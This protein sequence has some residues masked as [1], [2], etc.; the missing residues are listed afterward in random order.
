MEESAPCASSEESMEVEATGHDGKTLDVPGESPKSE[1][2][3]SDLLSEERTSNSNNETAEKS[4]KGFKVPTVAPSRPETKSEGSGSDVA[5]EEAVSEEGEVAKQRDEGFKVPSLPLTRPSAGR[6]QTRPKVATSEERTTEQK[7]SDDGRSDS[8]SSV[9]STPPTPPLPYNEP[10]WSTV[11]TQP[12]SLS[13]IK[14]GIIVQEVQL[15]N[16]PFHVFGRLPSCD[17]QLEHPSISRYHA[18][19][20]YRPPENKN[21]N[22]SGETEGDSTSSSELNLISSVSVNPKEEGFYVYD[23]GSTHGTQVNK[24]KIQPRCFYR[25]RL[26]QMVKFGGSSRIFLLE[27][28]SVSCPELGC[29]YLSMFSS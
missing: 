21:K 5:L 25:L 18:V 16:K 8:S 13:V 24:T 26:G 10:T 17:I 20:Q 19:L 27:V 15:S 2:L 6:T 3:S 1:Q 9:S 11:P 7:D 29:T 23:L 12:Y 22:D 14:N 28:S 4:S